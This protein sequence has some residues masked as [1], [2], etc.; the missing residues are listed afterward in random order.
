MKS[1]K[2][3]FAR[4]AAAL[5]LLATAARAAEL[6]VDL[7]PAD[8]RK[9]ILTPHWE[10]WAWYEGKSGPQTY[11]AV[12][13]TFRA[14]PDGVLAPV[15][16]KGSLDFG[17]TM[18]ADGITLKNLTNGGGIEMVVGGLTPGRHT[19]VTYHNEVRDHVAPAVLDVFVGDDQKVQGLVSSYRATNDYE[20]A[21]TFM[22]VEAVAGKDVVVRFQP[23]KSSANQSLIIN[24]F[25]IDTVNPHQ[26][27]I[28]PSPAND[29]EHWPNE[30]ALTWTAPAA[31]TSHQLYMGAD[32]G[33]VAGAT[34]SSPEFKGSLASAN[35][36]LPPLD[37]MKTYFWR[38]D[39]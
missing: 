10:N 37:Q 8:T 7:N 1:R 24:G 35:F 6:K 33:A 28:Q 2:T 9:D 18:A 31:A 13:V 21:G 34:P 30:S 11:G 32:P 3:I 19:L 27:A 23:E 16:F 29:D 17:A 12:P 5:F 4:M 22:E 15:L 38:V 39:E 36:L 20:V 26:K 14:V 25:E